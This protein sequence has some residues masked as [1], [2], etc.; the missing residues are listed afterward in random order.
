MKFHNLHQICRL[1]I[2][3]T[4]ADNKYQLVNDWLVL[5]FNRTSDKEVSQM[6]LQEDIFITKSKFLWNTFKITLDYSQMAPH[7]SLPSYVILSKVHT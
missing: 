3:V 2:D 5:S 1:I 4:L 6:D 7:F